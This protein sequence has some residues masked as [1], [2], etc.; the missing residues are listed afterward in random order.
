MIY[1]DVNKFSFNDD[2]LRGFRITNIDNYKIDISDVEVIFE[3]NRDIIIDII[4]SDMALIE[5]LK[6]NQ[7]KFLSGT[8]YHYTFFATI[9]EYFE[10][11]T[12]FTFYEYQIIVDLIE[13]SKKDTFFIESL[14][15]FNLEII[16]TNNMI[17]Y[18]EKFDKKDLFI[19]KNISYNE[20]NKKYRYL[21]EL[22]SFV[23]KTPI[24]IE[25]LYFY[26]D[27]ISNIVFQSQ[28]INE[29]ILDK[30]NEKYNLFISSHFNPKL[31]KYID[32]YLKLK[33][34][35]DLVI[36]LLNL[37]FIDDIY[38][39]KKQYN[40]NDISGFIDLFDGIFFKLNGSLEKKE[41]ICAKCNQISKTKQRSKSLEE[42]IEYIL[43]Q[44][45]PELKQ[46]EID[47]NKEL[48][49][50]LSNFRN[51]VRHQKPYEKFDLEKLI[52][53]LKG[54]L[55]LYIIKHILDMNSKD[56]DINRILSDFNIYP[57]VK[58]SYKYKNNEIIIYNTKITTKNQY[59]SDN[60][61]TYQTLISHKKFEDAKP[62]DFVYNENYTKEL[63]KIYI[64]D[65]N[66]ILRALIFFGII[67]SDEII[68]QDKNSVY[69]L[70]ISYSEL[71]EKL[72]TK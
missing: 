57:L 29:N 22:N 38:L 44:I 39:G 17:S 47:K 46:Y 6:N 61:V 54:T 52:I 28:H 49:K 62:D 50:A 19:F 11:S 33:K 55:R 53:F 5:F 58:H 48:S 69:H 68:I 26:Q 10:T 70:T 59:L 43:E 16:P 40:L 67:V 65:R 56:Y 32:N 2:R 23:Y 14:E 4:I 72:E 20:Y 15:T 18:M 25:K 63:K 36:M 34:Q 27:N 30:L 13:F 60:S 8:Y 3:K 42:K 31:E 41:F 24:L 45:E 7:L 1:L 71:L 9:N 37:Y 64:D 12:D 66:K 35:D 21:I 51:M